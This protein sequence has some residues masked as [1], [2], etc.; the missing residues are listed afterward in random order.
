MAAVNPS[1]TLK[2]KEMASLSH[3]SKTSIISCNMSGWR[4]G[5]HAQHESYPAYELLLLLSR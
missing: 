1:V 2:S 5:M 4:M 3:S